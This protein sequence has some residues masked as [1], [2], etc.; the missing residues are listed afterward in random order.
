MV[1]L[2]EVPELPFIEQVQK[3]EIITNRILASLLLGE[4]SSEETGRGF[5]FEGFRRYVYGVDDPRL[6]DWLASAKTPHKILLKQFIRSEELIVLIIFDTSA[7]M[8]FPDTKDILLKACASLSFSSLDVGD[9]VGFIEFGDHIKNQLEARKHRDG[10]YTFLDQSFNKEFEGE[11]DLLKPLETI[12]RTYDKGL[13][14]FISDFPVYLLNEKVGERLSGLSLNFDIIPL[15]VCSNMNDMTWPRI[16]I[17][18]QD[19]ESNDYFQLSD[20]GAFQ[21]KIKEDRK[22]RDTF[23]ENLGLE[24]AYIKDDLDEIIRL[25][26]LRR[27]RR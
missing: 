27:F 5:D 15:V 23:F 25:F 21:E 19:S 8:G 11:T 3:I 10:I 24:Y 18:I 26:A 2:V 20:F 17:T 14:F 9:D 22:K 12:A 13:L 1:W 4:H 7:S 6:I 16:E